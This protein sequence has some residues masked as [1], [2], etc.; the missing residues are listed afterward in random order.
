MKGGKIWTRQQYEQVYQ[1]MRRGFAISYIQE[2]WAVDNEI[3]K[4][5]D[6]S[7]QA[8]NYSVHA[9]S[10]GDRRYRFNAIRYRILAATQ[11]FPL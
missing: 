5:A 3:I 1:W 11:V 9:W 6:Y 4:A 10:S 7:Y 2:R 8:K